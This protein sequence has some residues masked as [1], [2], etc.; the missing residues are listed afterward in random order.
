MGEKVDGTISWNFLIEFRQ[1]VA[2]F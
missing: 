1:T 2:R